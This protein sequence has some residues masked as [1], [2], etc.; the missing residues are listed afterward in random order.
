MI[1][2]HV[3]VTV[4][5][6]ANMVI[7][8]SIFGCVNR[9][10]RENDLHYYR[11][12]KVITRQGLEC[13][14]LSSDRQRVWLARIGQD[15]TNKN[16][17]NVRVCSAHFVS[18]EK[19]YLHDHLN[20][21]WAPSVNLGGRPASTP[22]NTN[23]FQRQVSRKR[24]LVE[25]ELPEETNLVD[26]HVYSKAIEHVDVE[27]ENTGVSVQTDLDAPLMHAHFEEIQK[28][29]SEKCELELTVNSLDKFDVEFFRGNDDRV[30]HLTGLPSF[31]MIQL[32]FEFIEPY[33]PNCVVLSKFKLMTMTLM[34]LR[35][36]LS[37][38]FL[39]YVFG[40][41]QSSVSRLFIKTIDVMFKRMK[42]LIK[43]P[44][45]ETLR[46][47]MPMEFRK[48]FGNKCAVIIDCFKVFIEKPTGLK[49]RA[50]TWSSYK[51]H[52][53][54]KYLIG[55]T[56]QG[57]VSY[58][59]D[60][61]GGRVSDKHITE[62]S[63]FLSKLLPGD[64]V[65]ADRGFDVKESVGSVCAEVKIPAFTKGKDQLSALDIESTRKLAHCRIHVER[66]IGSV[67]QKYTILN[68]CLP[69]NFLMT[70]D[71]EG[72]TTMDKVVTVACGLVN[73]CDS[74]VDFN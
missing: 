72:I 23:R 11:I 41:N 47:T 13:E 14:K 30:K 34:K 6:L 3:S 1:H 73:L 50:Q 44:E 2:R 32:L 55:I 27:E 71:S 15:F 21:D 59:S 4:L 18:G 24:R 25:F 54:I 61:W 39:S 38:I 7:K 36:N 67:R 37:N 56:P 64:L 45:R 74:V 68:G 29:R 8:C 70:K 31:L 65:L 26:D 12:P 51:H 60:G 58:I 42:K 53:T 46:K 9:K 62:N 20:P 10:D 35:M 52:H 57:S 43:W 66:V 63:G 69:I 16:M 5:F 28:L 48:Y 19:A 22:V 17:D 49:A 40:I 33:L